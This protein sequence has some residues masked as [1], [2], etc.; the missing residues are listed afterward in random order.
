MIKENQTWDAWQSPD[1][2]SK[3]ATPPCKTAVEG[4]QQDEFGIWTELAR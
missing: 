3:A 2:T 1:P 4:H